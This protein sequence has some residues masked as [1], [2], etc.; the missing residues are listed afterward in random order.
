MEWVGDQ[1]E[2]RVMRA[3][4]PQAYSKRVKNALDIDARFEEMG[5]LFFNTV[6]SRAGYGIGGFQPLFR[7]LQWTAYFS[8]FLL[9]LFALTGGAAWRQAL[10]APDFKSITTLLLSLL[11]SLFSGKG[12]GALG[13]YAALNLFLAFRFHGWYKKR[14]GRKGLKIISALRSDLLTV[15]GDQLGDM[16]DRLKGEAHEARTRLDAIR[17]VRNT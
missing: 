4:L 5:D 6:A 1:A 7:V 14:L 12:L 17:E 15:W 8:L 16:I 2:S 11:H 13:T 3:G 9:L 10:S